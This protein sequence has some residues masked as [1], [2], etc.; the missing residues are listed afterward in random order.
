MKRGIWTAAALGVI[1]I[2]AAVPAQAGEYYVDTVYDNVNGSWDDDIP[3]F[4][5][6]ET[7][8]ITVEG[9]GNL[10]ASP[11]VEMG[12]NVDG[13][14][15]GSY[16]SNIMSGHDLSLL[17]NYSYTESVYVPN[18]ARVGTM[19]AQA[20]IDGPGFLCM[21]PSIHNKEYQLNIV[22]EPA[23]LSLLFGGLLG[24]VGFFRRKM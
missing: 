2:F 15:N 16:E 5:I 17:H 3:T 14:N 10:F 9:S 21:P 20:W 12:I 23:T 1:L 4:V 18:D 19:N 7:Y 24:M 22:P 11:L 8:D 13:D 6:G